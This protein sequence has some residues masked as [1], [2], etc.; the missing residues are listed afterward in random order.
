[1]ATPIRILHVLQRME[2]GG[3]QA[4]LMN[5]YRKIDRTKVQFDF[6]VEYLDREFYDDEIEK[7]GGKIYYNNVRKD[8]NI[9]K[10]ERN[11]E[12]VLKSGKYKIIHVHAYTIG[13]FV[14]KVAKK[15]GVPVRIAHSH[16]NETVRDAKYPMKLIMQKLYPIYATDYMA[17][18]DDAGKY[19]FKKRDYSVLKNAIDTKKF[20][21]NKEIRKQVRE[22]LR[23]QNKFVVG[24]VGRLYPEKNQ[25][26]LIEIFNNIHNKI[27]NAVLIIIGNGPL[28]MDLLKQVRELGL[29]DSVIFLE[30]RRDI[31]ELEQAFDVFI[32]PSLFEGLGIAAI[33]AQAAGIPTLCSTN[34]AK[35]AK[36]SPLY[37]EQSLEV[38]PKIWSDQAIEISRNTLAHTNTE[39]YVVDSGYDVSETVRWVT[40]F[41]IEK[42]NK[43]TLN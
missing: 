24:N 35:D 13:Y 2:A 17:C 3:T 18:S 5:L 34:V 31:N 33:E 19:L 37:N 41:Y 15:Y 38:D 43:V 20:T 28:K 21:F 16:E 6:F 1:M 11:L 36:I 29:E 26:F 22:K 4:L 23:L 32:F 12:K 14:L 40:E 8:K 25:K 30:N 42:Y 39:K 27:K 7:L 9:I 10:F